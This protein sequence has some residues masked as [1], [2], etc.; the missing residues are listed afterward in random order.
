MKMLEDFDIEQ[1]CSLCRDLADLV[2]PSDCQIGLP[3]RVDT[4]MAPHE[5]YGNMSCSSSVVLLLF[6]FTLES[7]AIG[8]VRSVEFFP[9]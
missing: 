9:P 7:V 3:H 4:W 1:E 5:Q 6:F 8:F 2:S